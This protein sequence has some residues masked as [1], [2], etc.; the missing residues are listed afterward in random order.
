MLEL[1]DERAR[2]QTHRPG[3]RDEGHDTPS[4]YGAQVDAVVSQVRQC[5]DP[6][7][8]AAYRSDAAAAQK[9]VDDL[10]GDHATALAL[11]LNAFRVEVWALRG[12]GQL[13]NDRVIFTPRHALGNQVSTAI[14]K[15]AKVFAGACVVDD[16]AFAG[17]VEA[18]IACLAD[19]G[20]TD[21]SP[22][23]FSA[24]LQN[25][26]WFAA[27]GARS[28][29]KHAD[30]ARRPADKPLREDLERLLASGEPFSTTEAAEAFVEA[31]RD[32]WPVIL[33]LARHGANHRLVNELNKHQAPTKS[34]IDMPGRRPWMA[35]LG[36]RRSAI[37]DPEMKRRY[38]VDNATVAQA[39]AHADFLVE[40][41]AAMVAKAGRFDTL[42]SSVEA[43]VPV[44]QRDQAPFGPVADTVAVPQ[45]FK[46]DDLIRATRGL[47]AG[48][49][50]RG[51]AA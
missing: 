38:Q 37:Y 27:A 26:T 28:A 10:V 13:V 23:R 20:R 16:D 11:R 7:T 21:V 12:I 8:L 46:L 48:R 24:Y 32:D 1:D 4:L 18:F 47:W 45:P 22:C 9:V 44:G 35:I 3:T 25:P 34:D 41:A 40:L 6:D 51:R 15:A 14:C 50:A 31:G 49:K 19:Q 29:A 2:A 42:V 5:S 39:R 36:G 17:H 43:Q 30:N 33:D